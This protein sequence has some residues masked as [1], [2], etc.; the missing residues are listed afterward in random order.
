MAFG[1]YCNE[2]ASPSL[3][4]VTAE[5][6][7]FRP[8]NSFLSGRLLKS[9]WLGL[10]ALVSLALSVLLSYL[11]WSLYYVL[12]FYFVI[13]ISHLA[14]LGKFSYILLRMMHYMLLLSFHIYICKWNIENSKINYIVVSKFCKP[15][16]AA[17]KCLIMFFKILQNLDII[18]AKA[19]FELFCHRLSLSSWSYLLMIVLAVSNEAT[20]SCTN[21]TASIYI[22]R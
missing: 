11:P 17:I 18:S 10:L 2:F 6:A 22:K 15:S 5:S 16:A 13:I 20:R 21:L 7:M 3:I 4:V 12:P 9:K 19:S 1:L 8:A 14:Q